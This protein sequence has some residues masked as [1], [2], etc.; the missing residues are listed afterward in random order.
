MIACYLGRQ[1]EG[2]LEVPKLEDLDFEKT[3]LPKHPKS[4]SDQH[5][6]GRNV[7]AHR[8]LVQN[9]VPRFEPADVH[10]VEEI[11]DIGVAQLLI[12]IYTPK[13]EPQEKYPVVF[14]NEGTGF[15]SNADK[16]SMAICSN[17]AKVSGHI[18]VELQI[19]QAPETPFSKGKKDAYLLFQHCIKNAEKYKIDISKMS[20]AG[21]SSGGNIATD[22]ANRASRD[23]IELE[24]QILI[25]ALIDLSFS[26]N[27]QEITDGISYDFLKWGIDLAV[28][29]G[30]LT[31]PSISPFFQEYHPK[32]PLTRF[33]V[34]SEDRLRRQN[35]AFFKKLQTEGIGVEMFV[36]D[37]VG[38]DFMWQQKAVSDLVGEL[39][40][41]PKTAETHKVTLK[42]NKYK[43]SNLKSRHIR[44]H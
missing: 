23:G 38:H 20:V 32:W 27:E 22:M 30:K 18:V 9:A 28:P 36:V 35:E 42:E 43:I 33:I 12:R 15:V 10:C 6:F 8:D 14:W 41:S 7:S 25:T 3:D 44:L 21:Y 1:R 2:T 37:K 34:G 26:F 16:F 11:V 29:Y 39:L 31:N 40:N 24:Q 5:F 19:R 4:G 13:G 17:I